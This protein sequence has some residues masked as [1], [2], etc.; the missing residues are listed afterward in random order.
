MRGFTH[1][2]LSMLAL[3]ASLASPVMAA[4]P[5]AQPT[6]QLPPMP[7][8]SGF[9]YN[10]DVT[11]ATGRQANDLHFTL[12]GPT[13]FSNFYT[14]SHF[15]AP[16]SHVQNP[17][18][19]W[20]V[21]YAST[22]AVNAGQVVHVGWCAN[23]AVAGMVPGQNNLPPFYWTWNGRA[24]GR[25]PPLSYDWGAVLVR[26]RLF[27]ELTLSNPSPNPI[28]VIQFDW[29]VVDKAIDLQE[30]MWNPL[31]RSLEWRS[32][33]AESLVRGGSPDAPG[34]VKA[35]VPLAVEDTE[36]RH[37]VFRVI[38]TD[39]AQPENLIRTL[40]QA[41]IAAAVQPKDGQR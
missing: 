3:S 15:G 24:I 35:V 14:G 40:G 30:L 8:G 29:A 16:K 10:I 1:K 20:S 22:T 4:A 2:M 25:I 13:A 31:E 21:N 18:G 6:P 9:C 41:H 11:N 7:G 36:S 12:N 34:V 38:A 5:S 33:D 23:K 28:K 39:P 27:V 37:M 17:S 26:D 32:L 19:S